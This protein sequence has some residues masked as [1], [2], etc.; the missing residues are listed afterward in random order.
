MALASCRSSYAAPLGKKGF[1]SS[2]E[3]VTGAGK[4]LSEWPQF[5]FPISSNIW[6]SERRLHHPAVHF[7]RGTLLQESDFHG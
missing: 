1:P 6:R 7:D 3:P 2:W 5:N 4:S